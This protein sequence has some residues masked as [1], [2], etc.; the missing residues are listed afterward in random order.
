MARTP[1]H[2]KKKKKKGEQENPNTLSHLRISVAVA[3]AATLR[4]SKV[5]ATDDLAAE[6]FA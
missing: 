1:C 4:T 2:G 5:S 3:T 6:E